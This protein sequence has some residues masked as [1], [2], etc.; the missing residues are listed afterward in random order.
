MLIC[1][2]S[3]KRVRGRRPSQDGVCTWLL[4]NLWVFFVHDNYLVVIVL[5]QG[6]RCEPRL[7]HHGCWG[8]EPLR[9][10]G[11]RHLLLSEGEDQL[12]HSGWRARHWRALQAHAPRSRWVIKSRAKANYVLT[13][14]NA[15][16]YSISP[17]LAQIGIVL[18]TDIFISSK[19]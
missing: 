2:G 3:G 16:P 1:V 19:I 5:F 18:L 14:G 4:V 11:Y 9:R 13:V 8:Q 12:R 6:R 17:Y 15:I 7:V 10:H